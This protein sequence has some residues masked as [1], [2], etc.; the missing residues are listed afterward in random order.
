[1]KF[2]NKHQLKAIIFDLDD[3]LVVE[4]ASAV[5]SFLEACKLA[6][7]AYGI[8]PADLHATLRRVCREF[9]YQAPARQY[10]IDAGGSSWEGLW[11]EFEGEGESLRILREWAPQYRRDSWVTALREHGVDDEPLALRMSDAYVSVRSQRHIVYDDVLPALARLKPRYRLGLLTNGFSDHQRRKIA[12]AQIG[13]WF[14]AIVVSGDQGIC[15]PDPA[16]FRAVLAQLGAESESA[17]MVG[18]SLQSDV[19]GAQNVGM[20]AVWVNRNEKPGEDDIHP[21]RLVK[22]LSGLLQALGSDAF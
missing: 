20:K 8:L 22:D 15:K 21:D 6:E 16:P 3:T 12:G 2:G 5:Y 10:C 11:A 4:E 9:W 17:W 14:D 7:A 13:G 19:Q 18:D 1:M